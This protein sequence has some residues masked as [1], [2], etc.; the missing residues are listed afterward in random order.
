MASDIKIK[1]LLLQMSIIVFVG[2]TIPTVMAKISEYEF[3]VWILTVSAYTVIVFA[4]F[5][6]EYVMNTIASVITPKNRKGV[7]H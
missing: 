2:L 5:K 4:G 3:S 1:K 6:I 7:S